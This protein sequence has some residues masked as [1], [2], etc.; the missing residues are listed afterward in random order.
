MDN[1]IRKLPKN[2][3]TLQQRR[4]KMSVQRSSK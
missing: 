4:K 3:E 1:S 2:S